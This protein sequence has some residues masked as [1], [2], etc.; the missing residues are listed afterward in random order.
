MLMVPTFDWFQFG[1]TALPYNAGLVVEAYFDHAKGNIELQLC[2]AQGDVSASSTSVP[3]GAILSWPSELSGDGYFL[4][5]SGSPTADV[6][7]YS[8]LSRMVEVNQVPFV[9]ADV[10]T[11]DEDNQATIERP[12]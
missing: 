6:V 3:A 10:A 8:F 11:V 2:N 1:A 4:R 5:V 9:T 7:T 12:E